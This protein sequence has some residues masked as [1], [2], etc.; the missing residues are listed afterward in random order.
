MKKKDILKE[1]DD[2]AYRNAVTGE[3]NHKTLRNFISQALD[4]A[5]EEGVKEV[6]RKL[7]R[8][9]DKIDKTNSKEKYGGNIIKPE[10]FSTTLLVWNTAF[11]KLK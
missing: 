10:A 11:R 6:K 3:A 5:E 7:L 8:A 9:A 4:Q 1:F 2:L